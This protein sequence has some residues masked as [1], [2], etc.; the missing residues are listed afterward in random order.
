MSWFPEWAEPILALLIFAPMSWLIVIAL[1]GIGVGLRKKLN[2]MTRIAIVLLSAAAGYGYATLRIAQ[3]AKRVMPA[4]FGNPS[5]IISYEIR[6][7][8]L[9]MA[10]LLVLILLFIELPSAVDKRKRHL[11]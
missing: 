9:M 8:I 5:L 10:V 1:L 2:L 11:M 6:I 3:I 4:G 7:G